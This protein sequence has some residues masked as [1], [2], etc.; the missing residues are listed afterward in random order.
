MLV[1]AENVAEAAMVAGL[2]VIP[3]QNL[4][5]AAGSLEGEVQIQPTQVDVARLFAERPD[6]ELDFSS[7]S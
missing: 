4:R 7:S 1:P 2:Q 5:E 6:D 3:V